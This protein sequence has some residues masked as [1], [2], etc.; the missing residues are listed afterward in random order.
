MLGAPD[1]DAPIGLYYPVRILT[2][3]KQPI[4]GGPA[5]PSIPSTKETHIPT[6]HPRPVPQVLACDSTLN[7]QGQAHVRLKYYVA[8][9]CLDTKKNNSTHGKSP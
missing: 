6:T 9:A 2:R 8:K 1:L 7:A 5:P 4:L 3:V